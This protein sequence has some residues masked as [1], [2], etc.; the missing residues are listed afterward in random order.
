MGATPPGFHYH[1]E[2][3]SVY[4]GVEGRARATIDGKEYIVE[5]DTVVFISPC[6]R[7]GLENIGDVPFKMIEV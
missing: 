2:R 5:P 4:I 7:H 3:E 1:T 6:E